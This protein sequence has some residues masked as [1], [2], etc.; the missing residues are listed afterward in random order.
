MLN[1]KSNLLVCTALLGLM[2]LSCTEESE[3]KKVFEPTCEITS[4]EDGA[5]FKME[6]D[7]VISGKGNIEEGSIIKTVLRVNDQV[8]SDVNAV[9]FDF[10]LIEPYKKEGQLEIILDVTADNNKV[11]SDTVNI[12]IVLSLIHI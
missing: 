6:D 12:E 10:T 3:V 1:M 9:P 7:I 8:V 4:P 5:S 2:T 11:A